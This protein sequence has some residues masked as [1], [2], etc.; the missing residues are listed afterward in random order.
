VVFRS[1]SVSGTGSLQV[2]V[3][4]WNWWSQV[5]IS[6]GKTSGLQVTVSRGKTDS[7]QVTVVV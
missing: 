4:E 7:L 3:S 1:Q 5:T 2:T 6:S